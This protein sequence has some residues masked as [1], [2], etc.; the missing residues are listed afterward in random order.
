MLKIFNILADSMYMHFK[1]EKKSKIDHG[2]AFKISSIL[3]VTVLFFFF[4]V[5]GCTESKRGRRQITSGE[6]GG[7]GSTSPIVSQITISKIY[8]TSIGANWEQKI[9]ANAR[10][11]MKYL[12]ISVTGSCSNVST[13]SVYKDLIVLSESIP[14]INGIFTM[15]HTFSNSDEGDFNILIKGFSGDGNLLVNKS[16]PFRLDLTAPASPIVLSPTSL[17]YTYSGSSEI[18]NVSGTI[19]SDVSRVFETTGF[20]VVKH[21]SNWNVDLNAIPGSSRTYSFISEDFAG[22]QSAATELTIYWS[23]PDFYLT[24]SGNT[25]GESFSSDANSN[26][27]IDIHSE[28]IN[29]SV[30][31]SGFVLDLGL[32]Q[33]AH[34]LREAP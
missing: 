1:Y 23:A 26:F 17:N 32:A 5:L 30:A 18:Y 21:L 28:P 13:L 4:G 6:S 20:L 10:H 2:P 7:S 12:N 15:D 3:L 14:C 24:A 29:A 25:I 34:L 19:N 27:K 31:N 33:L 11:H 8:P 9:D 22:N 16:I